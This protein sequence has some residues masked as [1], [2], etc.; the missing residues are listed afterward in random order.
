MEK[1]LQGKVAV[2]TGSAMGMGKEIAKLLAQNGARIVLNDL[3]EDLLKKASDEINME[4][5]ESIWVKADASKYQGVKQI[6][7]MALD[8]FSSI[9]ILVNN[10]GVLRSTKFIDID[11]LEWDFVMEVNLKSVYLC[12]KA[13]IPV[14]IK[15]N[16]GKIIN[17]SSS[18]G[19]S[20]STLGGAHYTTSKAAV[21]GLTRHL[22]KEMAQYNVNVNA[23]CPGLIDTEM[24]R[25][26][27]LPEKIK[28]YENS[29]PIQ[30][31]GTPREVADLVL[32]L[33][34][35]DSSYI[36]GASIDINGGDLM[37]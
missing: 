8:T 2:V 5:G 33:A 37:I 29:F 24:V 19:R 23:V 12:C 18:A 10:A 11:E 6:M 14:M 20:V 25:K 9:D 3:N 13:A 26:T 15:N 31:L 22:A 36:T 28:F 16:A 34:S 35:D 27:C 21:L 17:M 1:K 32:F 30:R 4:G 7:D